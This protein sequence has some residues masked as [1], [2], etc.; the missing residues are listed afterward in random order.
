[1][2]TIEYPRDLKIFALFNC[3]RKVLACVGGLSREERY[4]YH[5]N[6]PVPG[7]R[8]WEYK[9]QGVKKYR[10]RNRRVVRFMEERY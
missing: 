10:E 6:V 3:S 5:V 9:K 2:A 7:V 8:Y 4:K 1:M